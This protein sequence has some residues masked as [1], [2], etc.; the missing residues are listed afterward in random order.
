[1]YKSISELKDDIAGGIHATTL[2]SVWNIQSY[3]NR[4]I[5][6]VLSKVDAPETKRIDRINEGIANGV[7]RY[8]SP[9]FLKGNK[10]IKISKAT[11]DCF[12]ADTLYKA[13]FTHQMPSYQDEGKSVPT[14]GV[15]Y[16]NGEKYLKINNSLMSGCNCGG[17]SKQ[18]IHSFDTFSCDYCSSQGCEVKKDTCVPMLCCGQVYQNGCNAE[19]NCDTPPTW[20][21]HN[22]A[23]NLNIDC[24]NYLTGD[25][26]T[27]V[28][29]AINGIDGIL[30]LNGSVE[31]E[32]LCPHNI[33]DKCSKYVMSIFI[34]QPE[35]LTGIKLHFGQSRL[36]KHTQTIST[37]KK[38]WQ[39]LY[40]PLQNLETTGFPNIS[41]ITWYE[42][43]FITNGVGQSG[44]KIDSLFITKNSPY[45]IEYYADTVISNNGELKHKYT[46]ETDLLIVERDTYE[47]ILQEVLVLIAQDNQGGDSGGDINFHRTTLQE[48]YTEYL[49]NHKSEFNPPIHFYV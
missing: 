35:N 16:V 43:E 2:D 42:I 21:V 34:P 27:N 1:M 24:I 26:S 12:G 14:I 13:E 6:N 19:P 30:P 29:L 44:I 7:V 28:D 48:K 4:G 15:E 47:L 37:F 38:G 18:L 5:A 45:N 32:G 49:N 46:D 41:E 20:R 22:R 40:F 9:E 10:I 39:L 25:G 3:I 31:I 17:C 23:N 11:A 33:K 36:D 8:K